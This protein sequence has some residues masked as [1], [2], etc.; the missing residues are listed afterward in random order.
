MDFELDETNGILHIT[1]EA[2]D[3]YGFTMALFSQHFLEDIRQF[4]AGMHIKSMDEFISRWNSI[5][6]EFGL[7]MNLK[8]L[9][10]AIS[11]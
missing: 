1:S 2:F 9:G 10:Y 8:Y 7:F 3:D 6:G 5:K 4:F 11:L